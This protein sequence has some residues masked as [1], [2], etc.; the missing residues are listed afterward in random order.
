MTRQAQLKGF[1]S[2]LAC[3]SDTLRNSDSHCSQLTKLLSPRA[4]IRFQRPRNT[5]SLDSSSNGCE[6]S[7]SLD[8]S[9]TLRNDSERTA[10]LS[11]SPWASPPWASRSPWAAIAPP[12]A[13]D[14]RTHR[15][16]ATWF[17]FFLPSS[18]KTVNSGRKCL[19]APLTACNNF[20]QQLTAAWLQNS[21]L[22]GQAVTPVVRSKWLASLG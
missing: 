22:V 15:L 1:D 13:A 3:S 2:S 9:A 21:V 10:S 17:R 19:D 4:P 11:P 7:S 20:V 5:C 16:G 6:W 14:T 18:F 12:R 8:A